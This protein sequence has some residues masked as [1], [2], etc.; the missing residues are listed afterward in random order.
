[1]F[2]HLRLINIFNITIFIA[3]NNCLIEIY[4]CYSSYSII[5]FKQFRIKVSHLFSE[6]FSAN[7]V[8]CKSLVSSI[9]EKISL[10]R[11]WWNFFSASLVSIAYYV[12]L[13]SG[14]ISRTRVEI[15]L[16]CN[17]CVQSKSLLS[18]TVE[19]I[20]WVNFCF[21]FLYLQYPQNK[22]THTCG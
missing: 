19:K 4:Q 17:F 2:P 12:V 14:K 11:E 18:R 22:S 13:H 7:S 15:C 9:V 20:W 5:R 21:L 3:D 6:F 10:A 1:L 8:Q 16:C